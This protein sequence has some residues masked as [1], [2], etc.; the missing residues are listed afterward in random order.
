MIISVVS[1]FVSFVDDAAHKPR[2]AFRVHAYEEKCGFHICC[3]ENVQDLRC[4]SRIRAVVK[5]ERDL[6]LAGSALV[7]EGWEFRKLHVF[8][9]EITIGVHGELSQSV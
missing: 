4:P 8:R 9:R 1:D 2:V 6:M 7:I 3:L 5:S